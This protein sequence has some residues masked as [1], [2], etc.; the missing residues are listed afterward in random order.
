MRSSVLTTVLLLGLFW[1]QLCHFFGAF[2][3]LL[4]GGESDHVQHVGRV[5]WEQKK[6][7]PTSLQPYLK[8]IAMVVVISGQHLLDFQQIKAFIQCFMH[9]N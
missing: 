3:T 1:S 8:R 6:K 7:K 4:T 5:S 9:P 2:S